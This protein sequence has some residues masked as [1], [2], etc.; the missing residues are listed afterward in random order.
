MVEIGSSDLKTELPATRTLAP[1]SKSCLAFSLFTPPSTSIKAL[2]LV[3]SI[4]LL[5]SSTFL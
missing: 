5:N 4:R 1:E 2:E 3:F